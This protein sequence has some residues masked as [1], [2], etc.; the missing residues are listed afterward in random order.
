MTQHETDTVLT[1]FFFFLQR[2]H[3]EALKTSGI[4]Q[5]ELIE[6][7]SHRQAQAFFIMGSLRKEYP[8]GMRIPEL[9]GYVQLSSS[10]TSA[11]VNEMIGKDLFAWVGHPE[12]R[13]VI[14][15]TLSVLGTTIFQQF[16]EVFVSISE[17]K[18]N[19]LPGELRDHFVEAVGL[20]CHD[21]ED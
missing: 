16:N 14:R 9:A 21:F 12:D 13:L 20:L 5:V 3:E 7:L 19:E 8:E 10:M 15:V 1:E 18:L 17:K 2:L 11:L 6:T 4:K